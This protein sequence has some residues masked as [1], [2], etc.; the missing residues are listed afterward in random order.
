VDGVHE[1][2]WIQVVRV[3]FKSDWFGLEVKRVMKL[4]GVSQR[5]LQ[6][7]SGISDGSLNRMLNGEAID[8]ENIL[9]VADALNIDH[10]VCIIKNGERI[11]DRIVV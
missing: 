1:Q 8:I 3:E 11:R 6:A 10:T 4:T 9:S 2:V 5:M 7:R